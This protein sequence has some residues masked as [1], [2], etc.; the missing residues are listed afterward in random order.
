MRAENYPAPFG[1]VAVFGGVVRTLTR[2]YWRAARR[3][4]ERRT[5]FQIV[6]PLEPRNRTMASVK[7]KSITRYVDA[8]GKQ[9]K[10]STPGAH[11]ILSKSKKYYG[12]Y[13]DEKK[14]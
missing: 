11:K 1:L 6:Q 13:R 5:L 3:E 9:V 8:N 4:S 2:G 12:Q 10:G 7:R 14:S